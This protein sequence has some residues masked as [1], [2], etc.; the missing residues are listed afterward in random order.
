MIDE[1]ECEAKFDLFKEKINTFASGRTDSGVSS[2]GQVVH[3][4]TE[5]NVNTKKLLVSF[6]KKND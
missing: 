6:L 2:F 3:F 5:K 1:K 4:D